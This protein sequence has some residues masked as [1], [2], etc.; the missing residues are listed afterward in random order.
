MKVRECRFVIAICC[1]CCSLQLWGHTFF[2]DD[3][4]GL[5]SKKE[6]MAVECAIEYETDFY[7]RLFD[8][9]VV[10]SSD[11][12]MTV[13]SGYVPYAL[14]LSKF[15]KDDSMGMSA[16]FYVPEIRE[17][18][19]CKDKKY[20]ESFL[21]TTFHE[22]SHAFLHLH[23]G[24]KNIAPWFD[25]GMAKY[26]ENMT[27]GKKRTIHRT[28]TYLKARVKTLIELKEID[29]AEFV[30]WNYGRFSAE[31]FSQE[32]YGYAVGYCMVLFLMTHLGEAQAFDLFRQ[33][34]GHLTGTAV[35]DC[36]YPGGFVQ[37]ETDFM[38]YFGI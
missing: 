29:L 4:D 38:D 2:L 8:D 10:A 18:V 12:K 5:L 3:P 33:L 31:S 17:L 26:L 24:D 30:S 20:E 11:L 1:L 7:N 14:Y 6:K 32:G 28:D 15:I 19:V 21:A 16:G 37:F 27:Y 36:C 25:E 23:I 35:F 22:L 9:K 34:P 13:I